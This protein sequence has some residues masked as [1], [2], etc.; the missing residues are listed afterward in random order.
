MANALLILCI[1]LVVASVVVAILYG[2]DKWQAARDG[3][4]VSESLLHLGEL[5]GGWPGA[6]LAG[7]LFRHKTYKR[8]FRLV[9]GGCI[10][11]NLLLLTAILMLMHQSGG[12]Q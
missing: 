8:S 3:W 11:L 1:W 12:G 2:W 9:R 5:L 7:R 6:L 10:A 4:R